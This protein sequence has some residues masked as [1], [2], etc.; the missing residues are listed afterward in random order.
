[1]DLAWQHN[2]KFLHGVVDIQY[3]RLEDHWK[4]ST[5]LPWRGWSY[6]HQHDFLGKKCHKFFWNDE[7][8]LMWS[9]HKVLVKIQNSYFTR[10][11]T[12]QNKTIHIENNSYKCKWNGWVLCPV[13]CVLLYKNG[14]KQRKHLFTAIWKCLTTGK[15]LGQTSRLTQ[16]EHKYCMASVVV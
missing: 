3:T 1:M 14:K 4:W 5:L 13:T 8:S 2:G 10:S 12:F 16:V 11:Q 7:T 15:I 6:K 9:E